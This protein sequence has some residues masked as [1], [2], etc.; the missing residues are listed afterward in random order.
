MA[1]V[2][3][4]CASKND[5]LSGTGGNGTGG[6]GTG[7][8]GTG[9]A[10]GGNT[11]TGGTDPSSLQGLLNVAEATW[12]A[13]KPGCPDYSYVSHQSS[14]FGSCSNTTI[15][16]TNDQPSR[17]SYVSCA[18]VPDGGTVD[19]WTEVGAAQIYSHTEGASASTVEQL[20]TSCQA[21]LNN[22]LA[23]PSGYSVSLSFDAQGVPV[24]CLA[25]MLQCV[26]DCTG[27][28]AISSFACHAPDGADAG[29]D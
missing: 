1:V 18:Y 21:I 25:T 16:I 10:S 9:G 27:G 29:H 28:L 12:A 4:G 13:A 3:A 5:S 6:N 22:V 20:F 2:A 11:G 15:E 26:D 19:Q 7:G 8:D 17:R 24:T 23:D 14:V